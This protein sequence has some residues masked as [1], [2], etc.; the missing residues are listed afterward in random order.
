M[1]PVDKGEHPLNADGTPVAFTTY[2]DAA[3]YLKDRLGRY[4]SY[5]ERKIPVGL[6]VEHVVPKSR[7]PALEKAWSNFLLACINCNSHKRDRPVELAA[8]L[9]PDT[10]DT[11]SAFTYEPSGA[12]KV[13][14]DLDPA[15]QAKAQALLSL[16]GLDVPPEQASDADYRHKDRIE[17]WGKAKVA[18]DLLAR[19]PDHAR[20]KTR[21]TIVA[22]ATEGYSIWVTVFRGDPLMLTALA[23]KYPGTRA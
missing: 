15:E 8:H 5:C 18:F 13:A 21:A 3:P 10:D 12:I 23:M 14:A 4:C 11:L 6:A 7:Q 19:V 22:L 16:V 20:D 2:G 1:R 17:Q 9:W